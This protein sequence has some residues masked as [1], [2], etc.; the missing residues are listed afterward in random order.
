MKFLAEAGFAG[1]L[2]LNGQVL[3]RLPGPVSFEAVPPF[4]LELKPRN[5][6]CALIGLDGGSELSSESPLVRI[7]EYPEGAELFFFSPAL[8]VM[9]PF[10]CEQQTFGGGEARL[11]FDGRFHLRAESDRF[12]HTLTLPPGIAEPELFTLGSVAWVKAADG[13]AL[14]VGAVGFTDDFHTLADGPFLSCERSDKVLTLTRKLPDQL[15]HLVTLNLAPDAS[16]TRTAKTTRAKKIDL[17][18]LRLLPFLFLECLACGDDENAA[19]CCLPHLDPAAVR[20]F[21]GPFDEVTENPFGEGLYICDSQ[22]SGR[23]VRVEVEYSGGKIANLLTE[24]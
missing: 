4:E 10:V 24:D 18:P 5:G 11:L 16:L 1:Q 6:C 23:A 7:R 22:T 9:P 2:W 21:L 19:A 3:G 15:G 13:E 8:P 20:R 14:Y 12:V 17:L